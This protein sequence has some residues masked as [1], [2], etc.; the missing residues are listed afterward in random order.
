MKYY[1]ISL[2]FISFLL[3]YIISLESSYSFIEFNSPLYG[4]HA[5]PM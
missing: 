3:N 5:S 1:E 2:D 4:A